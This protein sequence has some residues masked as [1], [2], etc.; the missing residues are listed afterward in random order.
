M[1][2]LNFDRCPK[3][4]PIFANKELLEKIRDDFIE[5]VDKLHE[6]SIN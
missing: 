2:I 3:E 4:N 5:F 1:T 6:V